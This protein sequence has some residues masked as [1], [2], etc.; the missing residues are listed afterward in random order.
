MVH[1]ELS[2]QEF[3]KATLKWNKVIGCDGLKNNIIID[4]YDFIKVIIFK[5][6]KASLEEAVF[7]EKIKNTKIILIFKKGDKENVEN[8]RPSSIYPAF[9]KVLERIMYNR[10]YEYFMNN[11]L[12]HENQ[13]GFQINNST[14]HAIFQFTCDIA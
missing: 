8:Y 4:V 14:E 5:N 7:P 9:S 13:F 11:N 12:P 10:L 6:F 3:K 1:K 2:F